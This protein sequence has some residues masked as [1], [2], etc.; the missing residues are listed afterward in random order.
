MS[1]SPTFRHL[2]K[3]YTLHDHTASVGGVERNTHAV[4]VRTAGS[5]SSKVIYLA[6][7]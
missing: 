6:R 5:E 2:K 4:H 3:G 1:D 7:P